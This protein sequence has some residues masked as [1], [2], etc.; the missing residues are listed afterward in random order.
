MDAQFWLKNVV[1]A[2]IF[3]GVVALAMLAAQPGS[4]VN[5]GA[6]SGGESWGERE[7]DD[8]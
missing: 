5:P 6:F 7:W 1:V 2:G 4:S 8:D 3:L